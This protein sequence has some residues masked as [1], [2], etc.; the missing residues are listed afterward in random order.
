MEIHCSYIPKLTDLFRELEAQRDFTKLRQL[1]VVFKCIFM[2]DRNAL[3]E[4]LLSDEHIECVA[5]I[6][7]LLV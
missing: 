7:F 1:Y 5:F 3:L 2:L 6:L 4:T